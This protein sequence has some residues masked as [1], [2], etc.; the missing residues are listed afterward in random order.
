MTDHADLIKAAYA[1]GRR[2]ITCPVCEGGDTH[3]RDTMSLQANEVDGLTGKCWRASCGPRGGGAFI[4]AA[5]GFEVASAMRP[6]DLKPPF[7]PNPLR[8]PYHKPADA[9]YRALVRL[10]VLVSDPT[11]LVWQLTAFDYTHLG[12]V[13]RTA[14]KTIRTFKDADRPMYYWNGARVEENCLFVFED[15]MSAAWCR[16]PAIALLGTNISDG[17]ISEIKAAKPWRVFVA[18]DPGAEDAAL[19]VYER[20]VNAGVSTVFVPMSKDFKDMTLD[21][22]NELLAAYA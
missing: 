19:R 1:A 16:E 5:T 4:R 12:H 15:P 13:T 8:E 2:R 17:L 10:R 11:T 9:Q 7:V 14:D 3:E 21:E 20:L 22:R 18:L 6:E